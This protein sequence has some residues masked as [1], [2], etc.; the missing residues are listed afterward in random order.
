M[1]KLILLLSLIAFVVVVDDAQGYEEIGLEEWCKKADQTWDPSGTCYIENHPGLQN[2]WG[3]DLTIDKHERL[4]VLVDMINF[5]GNNRTPNIVNNGT[6]QISKTVTVL[7]CEEI[8]NNGIIDNAGYFRIGRT[9]TFHGIFD[10]GGKLINSEQGIIY[11]Y[12][13]IECD[14]RYIELIT[15]C[16]SVGRL[17]NICNSCDPRKPC[18]EENLGNDG[19]VVEDIVMDHCGYL[20]ILPKD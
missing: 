9:L 12:G 11:N 15:I 3:W 17:Y 14:H 18:G 4:V 8:I 10:C 1:R 6:I 2:M 5:E 16:R 20:P 13:I 7:N 19:G